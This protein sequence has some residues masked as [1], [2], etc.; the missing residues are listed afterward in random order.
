MSILV[1][2]YRVS[3]RRSSDGAACYA[4]PSQAERYL[5]WK[6]QRDLTVMRRDH[7]NWQKQNPEGHV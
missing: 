7:W 3:P 2:R 6:A 5:G 4:A 1:V